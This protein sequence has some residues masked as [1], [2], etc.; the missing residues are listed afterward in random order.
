MNNMHK[1]Y[2][3]L[4]FNFWNIPQSLRQILE[5]SEQGIKDIAVIAKYFR[6]IEALQPYVP[7]TIYQ[8][9]YENI[10]SHIAE[11]YQDTRKKNS[12]EQILQNL[13]TAKTIF[14]EYLENKQIPTHNQ[15]V[16]LISNLT[17]SVARLW[18]YVLM[19]PT[20]ILFLLG[21][22]IGIEHTRSD[23]SI[24]SSA[25]VIIMGMYL[26][27]GL[28]ASA[29][30][31]VGLTYK[32]TIATILTSIAA[33]IITFSC[34]PIVSDQSRN[35]AA[36]IDNI[37]LTQYDIINTANRP[38]T[39]LAFGLSMT[40]RLIITEGEPQH[41]AQQDTLI[42]ESQITVRQ[43][44]SWLDTDKIPTIIPV[45]NELYINNQPTQFFTWDADMQG[46]I[47]EGYYNLPEARVS[48]IVPKEQFVYEVAQISQDS[49]GIHIPSWASTNNNFNAT[50]L[51]PDIP[52]ERIV[53]GNGANDY[54]ECAWNTDLQ[55]DKCIVTGI[56][57]TGPV[58]ITLRKR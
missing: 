8:E 27:F 49:A 14:A 57:V 17:Y 4:L 5:K 32:R 15:T 37:T 38:S 43:Y 42:M 24:L 20:V 30:I 44:P 25:Q 10:I 54:L 40:G 29:L 33:T 11:Q 9:T 56:S 18:L 48:L 1:L 55:Q 51:F 13:G 26:L 12:V 21:I 19:V 50:I 46:R 47:S 22:S 35:I 41:F 28:C 23:Q 16:A 7:E 34:V 53:K 45:R 31:A 52:A 39:S 3:S 36:Q 2:L 58:S 6:S